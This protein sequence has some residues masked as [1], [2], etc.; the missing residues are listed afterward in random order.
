MTRVF[1]RC[2]SNEPQTT[3]PYHPPLEVGVGEG[4]QQGAGHG[5][6]HPGQVLELP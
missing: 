5:E 3:V 4:L 2:Q 6:V 1:C